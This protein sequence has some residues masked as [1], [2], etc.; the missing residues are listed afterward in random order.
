VLAGHIVTLRPGRPAESSTPRR[1]T[2]STRHA[3][4]DIYLGGRFDDGLLMDM[5]AT[6]LACG[7]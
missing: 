4:I 5:L 1:T 7:L 3:G 6:E 2:R